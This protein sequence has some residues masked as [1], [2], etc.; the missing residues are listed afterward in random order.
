M[1]TIKYCYQN[2]N[3]IYLGNALWISTG[4]SRF[5]AKCKLLLLLV[6]SK[7]TRNEKKFYLKSNRGQWTLKVTSCTCLVDADFFAKFP[8]TC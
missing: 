3:L 4:M 8:A 2:A 5:L 7:Y 1:E 6:H